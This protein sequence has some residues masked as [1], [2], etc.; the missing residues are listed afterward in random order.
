MLVE[1][2]TVVADHH[3]SA[4]VGEQARLAAL[5]LLGASG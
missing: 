2:A 4:G 3:G 5:S 1:G